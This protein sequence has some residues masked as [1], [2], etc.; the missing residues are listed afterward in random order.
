MMKT[1]D[2]LIKGLR[3]DVGWSG[4]EWYERMEVDGGLTFENLCSGKG[5]QEDRA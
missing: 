1:G 5:F 4:K 3:G 2:R